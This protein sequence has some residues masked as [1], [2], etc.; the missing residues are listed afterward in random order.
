MMLLLERERRTGKSGEEQTPEEA[1][2]SVPLN[3]LDQR[4]RIDPRL[5][6]GERALQRL[7]VFVDQVETLLPKTSLT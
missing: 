6:P 5:S 4:Y 1:P 7:C 2:A 3:F